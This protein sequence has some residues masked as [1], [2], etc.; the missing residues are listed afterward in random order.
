[1]RDGESAERAAVEC[2]VERDDVM[3]RF[4]RTDLIAFSTASAPVFTMKC[5]GVPAG[6]MRDSSAFRRSDRTVWYSECAYR[7][8]TNGSDSRIAE[9]TA[10]SFSPKACVAMS[11]PMSRKR[12]G[13]PA[14]S[15]ST[16][17]R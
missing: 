5:R 8:V 6:A 17:A 3:T 9:T 11:A 14:A 2:A 12:Y 13:W 4:M 7:V 10:G 16:A 1:M 15:R